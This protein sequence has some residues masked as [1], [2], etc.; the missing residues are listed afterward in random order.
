MENRFKQLNRIIDNEISKTPVFTEKDEQTILSVIKNASPSRITKRKKTVLPRLLT[1]AL[2]AGII[3][4]S[5]TLIANYLTPDTAI[6]EKKHEIRY[7]QEFTQASNQLTYDVSTREL[8]VKGMVK[9]NTNFESEPFQAKINI[10]S[11]VMASSLGTKSLVLDVPL[12][13][14]LK[15]NE[16]YSFEKVVTVDLDIVDENTFKDALE[17]EVYSKNKTLASFVMNNITYEEATVKEPVKS[18]ETPVQKDPEPSNDETTTPSTQQETNGEVSLADLEAKYGK[19]K[20][21]FER[22]NILNNNGTFYFNG[23]TVGMKSEEINRILGPY[24]KHSILHDDLSG[25]NTARWKVKKNDNLYVHYEGDPETDYTA[26]MLTVHLNEDEIRE[27]TTT[28]GEPYYVNNNGYTF[29]YLE[30]SQQLL[31]INDGSL[32]QQKDYEGYQVVLRFD[33]NPEMLKSV[34]PKE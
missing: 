26:R 28:L 25:H 2:F 23:I 21:P 9:N 24:D 20:T 32:V 18:E 14:V 33:D 19:K 27:L 12:N 4:A 34:P 29:Y 16:S 17:V 3:F 5:Y 13:K 7:A 11:D 31:Y 30:K 15:P 10:L 6:E 1:A 22:V 8:T